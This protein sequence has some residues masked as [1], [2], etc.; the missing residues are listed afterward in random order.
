MTKC[1]EINEQE[2]KQKYLQFLTV[3]DIANHFQVSKSSIQKQ[4]NKFGI[5]VSQVFGDRGKNR[6][7]YCCN[8]D[9]FSTDTEKSFYIAGFIAA[10]GCVQ[11]DKKSLVIKLSQKDKVHLQKINNEL[12]FNR[13][14][15]DHNY[16]YTGDSVLNISS[17]KICSDLLDK[18]NITPNKSKNYKFPPYVEN[19]Q[20]KN[21]FMRGYFDGDGSFYIN[22]QRNE[23]VCF[24]L[25]G[26]QQ[27]LTIYRDIL[28]K[29]CGFPYRDYCI[30]I[31]DGCGMLSYGGNRNI[32]K[33]SNFLYSNGTLFL[34]RKKVIALK[35]NHLL[36]NLYGKNS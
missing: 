11:Q 3:K 7:K 32:I 2:L 5:T 36:G 24:G 12:G 9:F 14:V 16:G 20:L 35:A 22:K 19:H 18:F 30:P 23:K 25:R 15:R 4:L 13:P 1:I 34:D 21:H 8:D 28:Q 31:S 10:D 33:I 26:T 29:E 6:R 27:F 17:R